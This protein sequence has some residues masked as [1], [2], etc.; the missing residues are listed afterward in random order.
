MSVLS[1]LI[2]RPC[3]HYLGSL[4]YEWFTE[5]I[6]ICE[7]VF[8]CPCCPDWNNPHAVVEE[9]EARVEGIGGFAQ[10][11]VVWRAEKSTN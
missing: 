8:Y 7:E 3:G 1:Q 6:G 4:G 11:M 10:R 2:F 9:I 5:R